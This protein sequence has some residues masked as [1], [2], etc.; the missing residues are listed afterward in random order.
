[1]N[2]DAFVLRARRRRTLVPRL[3]ASVLRH[4]RTANLDSHVRCRP[5]EQSYP[6]IVQKPL[7]AGSGPR[8]QLTL[9]RWS[10][11]P[12]LRSEMTDLRSR[13]EHGWKAHCLLWG[14]TR[15]L[16]YGDA[17]FFAGCFNNHILWI[18]LKAGSPFGGHTFACH[19]QF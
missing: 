9:V 19:K 15:P 12:G 10:Q 2:P 4:V 13:C 7:C 18:V 16:R 6:A 14:V 17:Q 1:M 11:F 8:P 3:R 5:G